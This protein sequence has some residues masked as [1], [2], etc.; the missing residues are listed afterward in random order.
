MDPFQICANCG[1]FSNNISSGTS[2]P[3]SHSSFCSACREKE[4]ALKH[5]VFQCHHCGK[6]FIDKQGLKQHEKA[7]FESNSA[8][9]V[10]CGKVI[11]RVS[12]MKKHM[13]IHTNQIR[14]ICQHCDKTFVEPGNLK[15]H[16]R[17]H[18]GEKPFH[19]FHCIQKFKHSFS[20]N[21]HHRKMH[22]GLDQYVCKECNRIFTH[23]TTL[24]AHKRSHSD[25]ILL[26]T[27]ITCGKSYADKHCLRVHIKKYHK[28]IGTDRLPTQDHKP[29]TET[30]STNKLSCNQCGKILTHWNDYEQHIK[31]HISV[32][33][34]TKN[35]P[36]S[37]MP[38]SVSH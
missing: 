11:S 1:K 9:C 19:C 20:L 4:K 15:T 27:C 10:V 28:N 36:Q 7:H 33:R 30:N 34:Y 12:N 24:R 35:T 16:L 6:A 3:S 29:I 5:Q 31:S 14:L 2:T 21:K 8:V 38:P 37:A 22:R 26:T 25:P 32:I 17:K 23:A 18:T 13:K